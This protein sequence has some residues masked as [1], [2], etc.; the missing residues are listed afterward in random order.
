MRTTGA[1]EAARS[2]EEAIHLHQL[3]GGK[4]QVA[5]KCP[6]KG[7][8]D[9]SVWY[10]PGAPAPCRVI[11]ADPAQVY[12]LTNKANLIAI[13]TDESRVLG[14]GNIGPR[15]GLPVMEGKA[16]LFKYLGGVDAVAICLG[17]QDEKEFIRVAQLRELPLARSTSKTSRSRDAFASCRNCGRL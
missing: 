8:A 10:T 5:P 7:P 11:H 12:E 6:I 17:P 1:V 9:F 4:M 16:M 14:L 15:A 2:D 13:L 3:Y